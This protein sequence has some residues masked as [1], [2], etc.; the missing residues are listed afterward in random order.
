MMSNHPG[1]SV[2]SPL[3]SVA[4]GRSGGPMAIDIAVLQA[5]YGAVPRN[6][7]DTTYVINGLSL[8]RWESIWDTG[9]TDWIEDATGS[10]VDINFERS[11]PAGRHLRRPPIVAAQPAG[12]HDRQRRRHRKRPGR[13]RRR[14]DLGQPRGQH[15]GGGSRC[16]PHHLRWRTGGRPA[17]RG[18]RRRHIP[19]RR[20]GSARHRNRRVGWW[21]RPR[22][23]I[24]HVHTSRLRRKPEARGL[25]CYR[26][27]RERSGQRP[28]RR[29]SLDRR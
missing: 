21:V 5:M 15:S 9:G 23:F 4:A 10:G 2:I 18:R 25:D 11:R 16:G 6:A 13:H 1:W 17:D 7:G 28:R 20:G 3:P 8:T 26:R 22:P 14:L 27:H 29:R 19:C 12:V 24:C